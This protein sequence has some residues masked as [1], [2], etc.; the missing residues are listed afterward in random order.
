MKVA[1][2]AE[3][4]AI[5]REAIEG[6]GIPSL[7]LMEQAGRQVVGVISERYSPLATRRV[8]VVCGR[9]NN[10]GDGLVVARMLLG[11]GC[12]TEVI[13]LARAKD[14]SDDALTNYERL[15]EHHGHR[16][17]EAPD[18][19]ALLSH[20]PHFEKCD[21]LVDAIFGTGLNS[22]AE[23]RYA[24]AIRRMNA[25][26]KPI[27]A[28]DIPSGL[29]ADEAKIIGEHIQAECTVTFGLPKVAHLIYPS[30]S[31]VG[32][33]TVADIGFPEDIISNA[34]ISTHLIS[35]KQFRRAFAPRD[36]EA[37]K[38]TYGHL[39]IISGSVGMAGA[40]VLTCRGALRAG[41]G[42]I[43]AAVP[44]S[45][46]PELSAGAVEVMTIPL[47]ETP[48]GT[49]AHEAVSVVAEELERFSAV[50]VGPGLTTNPDTVAFL[51]DLFSAIHVPLVIDADGCNAL[52]QL[53]PKALA[54]TKGTV[55]LTPHPGEMASLLE[56]DTATVQA[57]RL[58]AARE[59][60]RL[61]GAI[62]VLKGARTIVA[63]PQGEA[64]INLTG[65]PGMASGGVGDVLTGLIG[66]LCARR[67]E[68]YM[69]CQA[70]AYLHGYAGDL[71]AKEVGEVALT[72]SDL[73]EELPSAFSQVIES[74]AAPPSPLQLR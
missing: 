35:P 67:M 51:D 1:T 15:Y 65:N 47:P 40:C 3:M 16:I 11:S 18:E 74:P 72:A 7:E 33:L 55:C 44:R 27:V 6:A 17:H 24:E 48:G 32:E 69:A 71:A 39:L 22:P 14:L 2:A 30:A 63:N 42:L 20:A 12:P 66:S 49:I 25:T 61:Y 50:A 56:S 46:L 26:G 37:H 52:S 34:P 31:S 45:I 43:T 60:A 5:D 38:G 53:G 68:P 58:G 21:L 70:G 28:V 62:V 29:S 4:R 54:G 36:P 10:G 23:G 13:L 9:G 19:E 57:D 59:A 8:V 41:A 73:L 64:A